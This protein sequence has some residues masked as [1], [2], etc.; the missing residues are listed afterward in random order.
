LAEQIKKCV[1]YKGDFNFDTTKPDGT[2]RKLT[3]VSKLH[4]LGWKHTFS[5][6]KGV[7]K[8]YTWYLS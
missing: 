2:M 1:G 7:E 4:A 8:M 3:D 5:L 6:D